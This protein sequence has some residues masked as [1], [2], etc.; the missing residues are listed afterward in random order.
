MT[1][2]KH[3][4]TYYD[5]RGEKCSLCPKYVVLIGSSGS[6]SGARLKQTKVAGSGTGTATFVKAEVT[7]LASQLHSYDQE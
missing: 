1:A 2:C 5:A 6:L 4:R 7:H 3:E